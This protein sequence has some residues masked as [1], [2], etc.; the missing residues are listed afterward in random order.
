VVPAGKTTGSLRVV[1]GDSA[2]E[3]VVTVVEKK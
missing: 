2:T 1:D 3:V